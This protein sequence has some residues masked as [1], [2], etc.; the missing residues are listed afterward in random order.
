MSEATLTT[1]AITI[2]LLADV[3]VAM[4]LI[5]QHISSWALEAM[6]DP[7]EG[8]ALRRVLEQ[9]LGIVEGTRTATPIR[10]R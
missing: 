7:E 8:P 9:L 10:D 6:K 4:E 3:C 5:D 2:E 1:G